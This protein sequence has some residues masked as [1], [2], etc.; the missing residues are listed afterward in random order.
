MEC[1]NFVWIGLDPIR[2]GDDSVEFDAVFLD[3]ALVGIELYPSFFTL[4][5]HGMQVWV[6]V[7]LIVTKN[8]DTVRY[9]CYAL[10]SFKSLVYL[11]NVLQRF[12]SEM[13]AFTTVSRVG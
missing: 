7:F 12:K 1:R 5:H 8:N 11:E 6:M 10:A 4:L 9:A 2:A 13:H 3:K